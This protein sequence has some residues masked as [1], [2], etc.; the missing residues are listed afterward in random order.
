MA[1]ASIRSKRSVQWSLATALVFCLLGART[2]GAF[3]TGPHFDI[4][5][6]VL[7]SEGFSTNAIATVQ[8]A[9]FL[10]DFYEFIGKVPK[11]AVRCE[12]DIAN[13]LDS[14][15]RQHFDDLYSTKEVSEKWDAMLT[16]TKKAAEAKRDSGDVLGL[17]ALLGASLHNVQDFYAH[18][19]WVEPNG[20]GIGKGALAKYGDHPTWLSVDRV[21]RDRL[22]VYTREK[23][24][25]RDVR[26]HGDWN[27]N[28][29]ALNKDWA[30]RPFYDDA[31][32]CAYFAS[33]QW[34]RLFQTFV[35][36]S[37][38]WTKMQQFPVTSFNPWRDWEY[39]RKISFYG[40][41]WY[42]NGGPTGS[43]VDAFTS[44]AAATSPD[45]LIGAVR[46][47]MDGLCITG[48]RSALRQKMEPMLLTWG[49]AAFTGPFNV[50]LPSASPES[51]QFVQLQVRKILATKAD[52]GFG[53]GDMDWYSR[54]EIARQSYWS[55]L[56][57]EH[58]NFDFTISPY[59]PWVMTKALPT[60]TA[61][62]PMLFKLMELDYS[63]DDQV[64]V[65]PVADPSKR[66]VV[67]KYVTSTGR[68]EGDLTG[69]KKGNMTYLTA[70]GKSDCDCARV[71][72]SVKR[73][74]ASS[75]K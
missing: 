27:S 35:N 4:T 15:D 40:G 69:A 71:D 39:A 26:T 50:T 10:V 7:R 64:D 38:T 54:V 12:D 21:D 53:G 68:V 8:S 11:A 20:P 75:L 6:D 1:L 74:V 36:Q 59:A 45:L 9:N 44:K 57:D 33:R 3:D 13:V 66:S 19:N 67:F 70:D 61:D 73:V 30:G 49:N 25:N 52:D 31:Y 23:V 34:V 29:V 58:D 41:H 51:L 63:E 18:S 48:K 60:T 2:A 55:G 42:G 47:Y 56:I 37:S 32:I 46:G 62:V 5:Q 17:M 14:G 22:H 43:G 65:N 16:A 24:A 28:A 72:L